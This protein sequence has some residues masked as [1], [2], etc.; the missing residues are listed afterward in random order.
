LRTGDRRYSLSTHQLSVYA[1]LAWLGILGCLFTTSW[2]PVLLA[3]TAGTLLCHRRRPGSDL[4]EWVEG[5]PALVGMFLW[6]L[7]VAAWGVVVGRFLVGWTQPDRCPSGLEGALDGLWALSA[8]AIAA[9]AMGAELRGQGTPSHF[10]PLVA[11]SLAYLAVR[12]CQ[13][14]REMPGNASGYGIR[15]AVWGLV[16]IAGGMTLMAVARWLGMGV[17][18]LPGLLLR[19][20][21]AFRGGFLATEPWGLLQ[22]LPAPIML[23]DDHGCLLY[24]NASAEGVFR[25]VG[26]PPPGPGQSLHEVPGLAAAV[27]GVGSGTAL[28]KVAAKLEGPEGSQA[29]SILVVP[30]DLGRYRV[31]AMLALEEIHA[32]GKETPVAING[33]GAF[34]EVAAGVVH[35]IRNPLSTVRGFVQLLSDDDIGREDRER[36]LG[37]IAREIDRIDKILEDLLVLV[38]PAPRSV[39][40]VDLV[41]LLEETCFMLERSAQAQRVCVLRDLDREVPPVRGDPQQLRQVFFNI[42][43][44]ALQAMPDG[45]VLS[46]ALR[47]DQ[48]AGLVRVSIRDTGE[49]I[50]SEDLARIFNPFFT[51]KPGGTGLGLVVSANIVQAYGGF[52]EVESVPGAGSTFTVTLPVEGGE[53]AEEP[54]RSQS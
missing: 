16:Y 21:D 37:I 13:R 1:G 25:R 6:G 33:L 28:R 36:Y 46:V 43:G 2:L 29:L 22:Q 34:S 31:G 3:V 4:G 52:I 49:G 27:R 17:A 26:L 15:A 54:G 11:S 14:Q 19:V 45:G 5:L 51:T 12:V 24:A 8:G 39:V 9:L 40:Q 20:A 10:W 53:R 7:P 30:A 44:N 23:V 35:E 18:V 50:P 32:L 42:A 41:A 47:W 38:R 48:P